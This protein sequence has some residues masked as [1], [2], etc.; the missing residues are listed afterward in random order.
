MTHL[1]TLSKAIL[2]GMDVESVTQELQKRSKHARGRTGGAQS[3]DSDRTRSESSLASSVEL[4]HDA[5]SDAASVS[6]VDV[7]SLHI[8]PPNDISTMEES[9]L[10]MPQPASA[11]TARESWVDEFNSQIRDAS[12]ETSWSLPSTSSHRQ[13]SSFDSP[14][15]NSA[16]LSDSMISDSVASASASERDYSRVVSPIISSLSCPS[17]GLI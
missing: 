2:D 15:S 4:L 10:T 7:G 14:P 12:R 17:L 1:P 3:V 8:I 13:R 16:Y 9:G 5:R 6:D 11:S